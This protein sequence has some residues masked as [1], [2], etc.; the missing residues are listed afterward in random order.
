MRSVDRARRE[1]VP[2]AAV[3]AAV[4][5]LGALVLA[6][7]CGQPGASRQVSPEDIERAQAALQPFKE[8][9][10]GALMTALDGG[11][12]NAIRVCRSQAPEIASELS[13][14]GVRMGRTSHRLRNLQNAPEPWVKPLLAT[15]LEEP[16]R[17][18]PRA[19]LLD[20]TT[21]GYVEPI[22]MVPFC[23][24]CHGPAVEAGLLEEIRS[25]YPEDRATGFRA[26][27]LRGLFWV[28][29]PRGGASAAG[30]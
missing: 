6:G 4:V 22:R 27:D 2:T 12:E 23:L 20:E 1:R 11:P 19:V 21:F 24:S 30:G 17:V 18:E 16:E 15:Y 14:G 3:A 26:G 8:R 25:L 28:T 29:M 10:Q 5:G 13:V 9:L 7:A